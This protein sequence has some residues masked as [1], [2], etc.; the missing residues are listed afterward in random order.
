MINRFTPKI[1]ALP[2]HIVDFIDA[3]DDETLFGIAGALQGGIISH[4]MTV[5]QTDLFKRLKL[6]IPDLEDMS[7]VF[8]F[9]SKA[10][11]M[12]IDCKSPS[13]NNNQPV[14]SQAL[15]YKNACEEGYTMYFVMP[16][17]KK[18]NWP[19]NKYADE[20]ITITSEADFVEMING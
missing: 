1:R 2:K 15:K 8:D 17:N 20:G 9:R 4:G 11:K 3:H 6:F 18:I 16:G 14:A 10:L 13:H 5:K 19:I 12:H 7:G